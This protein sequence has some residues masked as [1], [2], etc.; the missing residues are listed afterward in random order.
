MH[1]Q[2]WTVGWST[3]C[4]RMSVSPLWMSMWTSLTRSCSLWLTTPVGWPAH[5][6]ASA[7]RWQRTLLPRQMMNY[8][9][10]LYRHSNGGRHIVNEL[11]MAQCCHTTD[12]WQLKSFSDNDLSFTGSG[13][14]YKRQTHI[15]WNLSRGH[16]PSGP[17]PSGSPVCT[18]DNYIPLISVHVTLDKQLSGTKLTGPT[19]TIVWGC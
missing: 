5:R 9:G 7:Q 10:H 17:M 1:T 12:Q 18:L 15:Q 4:M 16:R 3:E 2:L 11:G 13:G 6:P 19:L 8:T 14:L